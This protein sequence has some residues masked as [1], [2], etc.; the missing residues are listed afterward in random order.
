MLSQSL[1][2]PSRGFEEKCLNCKC[3]A[4]CDKYHLLQLE[5]SEYREKVEWDKAK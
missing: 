3:K 5:I 1:S 4:L 2:I